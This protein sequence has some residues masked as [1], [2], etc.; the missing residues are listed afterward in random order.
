VTLLVAPL[1]ALTDSR[2]SD[3]ERRV[4]LA[5]FSFRGKDT[6]T[7]WPGLEAIAERAN[8]NDIPRIS[9]VTSS[10][11][12]K[13]WLT[14]KKRGFTGCNQYNLTIPNLEVNTN[15]AESTNLEEDANLDS[16]TNTNLAKSTKSNLAKSTKY[17]E[18]TIE[19]TKEQTNIKIES[20]PFDTFWIRYPRKTN[21]AKAE[22]AWKKLNP[23]QDLFD[24]I[25]ENIDR[26][27]LLDDWSRD[28][29]D[30]IPHASTFLNGK[31]WEDEIVPKTGGN[32][33]NK[34]FDQSSDRP[35]SPADR[36]RA[37]VAQ[38]ER[39]DSLVGE[40]VGDLRPQMGR[41]VRDDAVRGLDLQ[42]QGHLTGDD[43][44]R[45]GEDGAR[46]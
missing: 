10:L 6:N 27:L 12:A 1:E 43:E 16:N 4:L 2:L 5:L 8:I 21:R 35:R 29:K 28:R 33:V 42:P 39:D 32:H 26:R 34:Q 38:Q 20:I 30:F 15:L 46:Q 37:T 41:V 44:N 14:K 45:A 31:N 24:K 22:A 40:D 23:S 17:K 3:S 36:L 11:A 25:I 18:Q 9:K 13:G 7:V 19:Q